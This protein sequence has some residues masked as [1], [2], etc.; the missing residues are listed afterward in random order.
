[1]TR[2]GLHA[3]GVLLLV[4]VF[5]DLSRSHLARDV[6]MSARK[7]VAVGFG[8]WLDSVHRWSPRYRTELPGGLSV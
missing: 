5:I 7:S 2:Y 4:G 1:M 6:V 8:D 3:C